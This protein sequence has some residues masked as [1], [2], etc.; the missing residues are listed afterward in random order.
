MTQPLDRLTRVALWLPMAALALV[1]AYPAFFLVATALK[2]QTAYAADPL[3]LPTDPTLGNL[4][5][6]WRGANVGTYTLNSLLV[7]GVSC[8]L[9]LV[10]SSLAGYAFAHLRF[11]FRAAGLLALVAM[12]MIP[13]SVLMI[14]LFRR[15]VEIGLLNSYLGLILVYVGLQLPFSAYLM[16]SYFRG[17]PGE[18][19]DAAEVDGASKLQAFTR[20]A[21]P[22]ARPALL[23]LLT[24]NFLWLWNELLFALI[25]LQQG[26]RRTL[27][28]GLALLPGQHGADVPLITAGLLLAITPPLLMFALF[29]RRLAEGLTAGALK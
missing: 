16:T 14:P 12:M 4:F 19:L 10:C 9:L 13:P 2:G 27:M 26:G 8:A 20:I 3:G 23:T 15:L 6:A 1:C 25:L 7:V 24:L 28:V 11:R 5:E 22:L 29:H 21:L 17:V 18:L